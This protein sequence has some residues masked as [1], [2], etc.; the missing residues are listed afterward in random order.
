MYSSE[1]NGPVSQIERKKGDKSHDFLENW[2][3][4][5]LSHYSYSPFFSAVLLH[6]DPLL[7]TFCATNR[8]MSWRAGLCK[9]NK[10]KRWRKK[11]KREREKSLDWPLCSLSRFIIGG[12]ISQT[13]HLFLSS[14]FS[15]PLY[16]RCTR[17]ASG[18]SIMSPA[19]TLFA[20]HLSPLLTSYAYWNTPNPS[21]SK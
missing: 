4:S 6:F 9:V 14:L 12:W 8:M 16:F 18:E 3:P 1:S 21:R 7:G 15:S 10:K 2:F 11:R 17:Q 5:I 19:G 20:L 13:I